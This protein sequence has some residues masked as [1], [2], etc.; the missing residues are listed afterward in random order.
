METLKIPNQFNLNEILEA[1]KQL[2]PKDR[3]KIN[4][5]IWNE[6]TEIPIEHQKLVLNRIAKSKKNPERLL[7]WEDVAKDL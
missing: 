4:D 3:L 6:E 2:S 7:I 5:V 1:I